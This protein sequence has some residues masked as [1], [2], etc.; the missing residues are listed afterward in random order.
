MSTEP[1]GGGYRYVILVLG[2]LNI[3]ASIGL[4]R[5]AYTVVMPLM[6]E[7]LGLTYTEM[8]AIGTLGF[9]GYTVISPLAGLASARFGPRAVIAAALGLATVGLAGLATAHG[10]LSAVLANL[11]LQLGIAGAN[12]AGFVVVTPWFPPARR[13]MATGIVMAGAGVGIVVTGRVLPIV[14]GGEGGWRTA[15]AI[16]AS[17]TLGIAVLCALFL[18]DHGDAEPR[19]SSPAAG[20]LG[21]PALWAYA[22]LKLLF[23]FEYIIFGTFFAAHLV[24]AG[25]GVGEA[26]RL[27]SLVG[28]L[29]IGSGLLAGALSDRI[30]RMPA[31]AVVFTAQGLAS[32][33]LAATPQGPGLY[34]AIALYGLSMMGSPAISGPFC[35]DLVGTRHAS[36]AMGTVNLLFATGQ[37]LGPVGAGMVV[38]ATGSLGLALLAGAA[39]ALVGAGASLALTPWMRAATRAVRCRACGTWP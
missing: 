17:V 36:A 29:M 13:G 37:M 2:F 18:R 23:G 39:V 35:A 16:A 30:G 27:W 24:L 20:V 31:L 9:A 34:A 1:P 22:T 19:V 4:A 10:F 28:V 6:R 38:D 26:S 8:G 33:L 7:G 3:A 32:L 11:A 14:L 5:F 12:A 15:W 21:V 25:F